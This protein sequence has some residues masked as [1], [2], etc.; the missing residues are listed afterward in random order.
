LFLCLVLGVALINGGAGAARAGR[1]W[2]TLV[3]AAYWCLSLPAVTSRLIAGLGE[4]YGT[5]NASTPGV[6]DARVLVVIG[7][8]SVHYTDGRHA[9]D[10]LTRRSVFCVFE[11]AR[12]YQ[13]VQPDLVIA[14]GG[15]A[16]H[17][18][19]CPEGELMAD[20]LQRCRVPPAA[21]VAE[22]ASRTTAE[23]VSRVVSM[24]GTSEPNEPVLVVTTSA[25]MQR[26][27]A[28]FEAH[29]VRVIP[30]ITPEL[31]YDDGRRGWRRWV[32]SMAALTGST[33][34]MYEYMANM[35]RLH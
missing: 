12:V 8:G 25:H 11:A 32:P 28:L 6:A 27:V 15:V 2:L 20:L 17:P 22:T 4:R 10:Y 3:A 14:T 5:I 21:I 26:V 16:G 34:A 18:A 33:S 24:L 13:L 35:R 1:V 19:A 23:Q 7:N 9:V 31:R 29:N 30:S